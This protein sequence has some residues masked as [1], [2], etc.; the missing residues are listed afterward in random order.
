ML[1][2]RLKFIAILIFGVSF[3][4]LQA[5]TFDRVALSSGGISSD[6]INATIGEIFVFSVSNAGIS[7][8]AGSQSGNSNTGGISS[9]DTKMESIQTSVFVYPNP[10]V[11]FLNLQIT[12]LQSETI[13]FQ[14]VD[15]NGKVVLQQTISNSDKTYQV[16]VSNLSAGNY[17]VQGYSVSGEKIKNIKFIK[18]QN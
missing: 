16:N 3:T 1:Y 7:F 13:T 9:S 18:L 2:K 11:A 8:G 4:G 10:V 17:I 12:G 5:Q 15:V 6:T 14:V